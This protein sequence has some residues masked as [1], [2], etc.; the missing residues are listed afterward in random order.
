MRLHGLHGIAM[1]EAW[2]IR[3]SHE[4]YGGLWVCGGCMWRVCS[5]C[6]SCGEV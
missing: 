4:L 5:G 1:G 6:E 2:V 3:G